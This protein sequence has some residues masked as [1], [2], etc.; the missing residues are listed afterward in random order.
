MVEVVR[1]QF[2]EDQGVRARLEARVVEVS[3]LIEIAAN[4]TAAR[5]DH[6]TLRRWTRLRIGRAETGA[7]RELAFVGSSARC[8]GALA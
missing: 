1:L 6:D 7:P 2:P 4:P 3:A 8:K 5:R